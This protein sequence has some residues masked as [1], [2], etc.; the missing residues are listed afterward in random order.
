MFGSKGDL[1]LPRAEHSMLMVGHA[2]CQII[3]SSVSLQGSLGQ[4][5]AA[6]ATSEIYLDRVSHLHMFELDKI[7]RSMD[8]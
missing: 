3:V 1:G 2:Q 6:A 8:L 7:K 4:F 5:K